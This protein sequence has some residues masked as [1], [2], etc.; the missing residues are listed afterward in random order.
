MTDVQAQTVQL[1]VHT[2]CLGY[3][4]V[5]VKV[6]SLEHLVFPGL[7]F[8]GGG[9]GTVEVDSEQRRLKPSSIKSASFPLALHLGLL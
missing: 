2:L 3:W 6:C 5:V 9:D 7:F 8:W 1:R 4:F